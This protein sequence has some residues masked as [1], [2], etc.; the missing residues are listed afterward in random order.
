LIDRH[1]RR[2]VIPLALFFGTFAWSFVY[3]SL[4]FYIR[5]LSSVAPLFPIV[6]TGI[7]QHGGG[8]VIGMVNDARIAA[9]FVGPVLATGILAWTS[10]AIL[11]V[12]VAA[13]GLGCVP[14]VG[15]GWAAGREAMT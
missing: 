4:P 5:R 13:L 9:A 14:L 8:E 6:V 3:V 15:R 7:A 11:Y 1:F 12:A 2:A 10:P